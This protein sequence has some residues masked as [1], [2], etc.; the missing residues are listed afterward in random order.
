MLECD[1]DYFNGLKL[2]NPAANSSTDKPL[3]NTGHGKDT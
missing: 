3:I 2:L 1:L